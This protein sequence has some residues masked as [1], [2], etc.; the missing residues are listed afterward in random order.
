MSETT[1]PKTTRYKRSSFVTQLPVDHL[2]SPSHC[3]L[4]RQ[5]DGSWR[6]GLT[7]FAAR[8]LGE[9]VDC[10]FDATPG[11]PVANG[12]IIG[13]V[14]GFKA[15]SDI[16]C[17]FDGSF[18]GV[19]PALREKIALVT[20]DPHVGGWLYAGS[21][22]PDARC[23]D[24]QAYQALLDVTIDRILEKQKAEETP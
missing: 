2:Y 21:G 14:E 20:R 16:Y 8:M 3:W 12:Q 17:V 7:K 4:G 24:V 23:M 18:S 6:V 22:T 1:Q 15:I 11:S 5:A 19:N 13:W 9:M 10:G